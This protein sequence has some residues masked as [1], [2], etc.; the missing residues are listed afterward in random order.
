MEPAQDRAPPTIPL[1]CQ[2]VAIAILTDMR[3]KTWRY[4]LHL[5]V[6]LFLFGL[7]AA[8][9]SEEPRT[10]KA[11]APVEVHLS[12]YAVD[13]PHT[14]PAGPTAFLVHNDGKKT[15]SLKIEGPGL[16][17]LLSAPVKPRATASLQ[18]TLQPGEYKVYCPIGSHEPRGM[19][20]TL[21]VTPK[22]GG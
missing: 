22:P 1:L 7:T 9:A 4:T 2:E 19:K 17:E 20:M 13:M 8:I 16:D 11:A 21:T 18:V 12:E 15:H 3:S 10:E 6:P 5:L 14:L